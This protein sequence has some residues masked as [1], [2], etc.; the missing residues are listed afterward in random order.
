MSVRLELA[1]VVVCSVLAFGCGRA[2]GDLLTPTCGAPSSGAPEPCP[3]TW[4]N[5]VSRANSDPWLAAH[6]DDLHSIHPRVLLLHFY[7]QLSMDQV[8]ANT[9]QLLAA[10]AEGSRYHGYTP[11][12]LKYE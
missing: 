1:G 3:D 2:E 7:N 9:D 5:E 6:H 11:Q 10:L 8:R 12:F 4:P